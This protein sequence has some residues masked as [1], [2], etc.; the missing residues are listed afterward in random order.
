[1]S[2]LIK[3]C[4]LTSAHPWEDVRVFY[5]ECTSLAGNTAYDVSLISGKGEDLRRNN[6]TVYAVPSDP[7]QS[8]FARMKETVSNV[9]EKALTVDADVY[10]LHDPELLRIALKLK[11]RGKKVIY[12]AHEDL[13]RQI[14]GKYWI[15]KPLRKILSYSFEKYENYVVKRLDAVVAATP[16][17]KERFE[18]V[19]SKTVDVNNYPIINENK[20][21]IPDLPKD[22]VCYAGGLTANRG[23]LC[24]VKSMSLLPGI[25]LKLA[26]R[27]S[28]KEFRVQLMQTTGWGSVEELGYISR[29]EIQKLI[30]GSIAGVVT[31]KALPNYLDSLPIKM[32]EYMYEGIPVIASNFPY[33]KTIIEDNKCGVCVDPES[34]HEIS[35]AIKLFQNDP[36][37]R[38]EM[39]ERGRKLVLEKY[40]WGVE[41]KK[42]LQLYNELLN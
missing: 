5:K 1:M 3:I 31:L 4:H 39:G 8:R 10:H 24:L 36:V 28:P 16:F 20:I 7:T 17:I 35:Q 6:V 2:K 22:H 18:K 40:N 11:K 29:V 13:P 32:F 15:P 26:G 42:L 14:L 27:Y 19:N 25:K 9:Y 12:D 23:I 41:E 37:L 30:K 34:E 33:W 21:K 38:K